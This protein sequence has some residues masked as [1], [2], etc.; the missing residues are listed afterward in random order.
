V[1]TEGVRGGGHAE[2]EYPSREENFFRVHLEEH[3][4]NELKIKKKREDELHKK[5]VRIDQNPSQPQSG[6]A[7]ASYTC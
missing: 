5:K 4:K 3:L 2:L 6:S 7:D 1:P